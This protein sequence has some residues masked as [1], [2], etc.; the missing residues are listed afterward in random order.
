[1]K[2]INWIFA[3]AVSIG[4]HVII[5]A[6]L[7]ATRGEKTPPP[8]PES[9]PPVLQTGNREE[10]NGERATGNGAEANGERATGNGA[11]AN[12][13]RVTGNGAEGNGERTIEKSLLE[14]GV[15]LYTVKSGDNLTAISKMCGA[16]FTELAAMNGTTVKK[17]ANLRVGQVIKVKAKK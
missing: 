13:E 17:L 3:L 8:E 9:I 12:G 15:E 1:M 14:P 2:G 11:E 5:V 6:A 10:G 7:I 4:A 16:T